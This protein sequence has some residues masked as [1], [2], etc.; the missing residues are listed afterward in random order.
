MPS[1]F[2]GLGAAIS[3]F[4]ACVTRWGITQRP[5]SPR[6]VA[7]YGLFAAWNAYY[8]VFSLAVMHPVV[9]LINLLALGLYAESAWLVWR[10]NR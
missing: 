7:I 5:V 1:P 8:C 9:G 10:A 4:A 2:F 3:L 6:S